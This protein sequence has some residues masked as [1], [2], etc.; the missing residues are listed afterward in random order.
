MLLLRS[1]RPANR[2]QTNRGRWWASWARQDGQSWGTSWPHRSVSWRMPFSP[3]R[4]SKA[5]VD[6]SAPVVSVQVGHVVHGVVEVDGVAALAPAQ[7][8]GFVDAAL[9]DGQGEQVGPA[10]GEVGRVEGPEAGPGDHHVQHALAVVVDERDHLVADPVLEPAV[11]DGAGL[12][13][14]VGVAPAGRVVAVDRVDLD[15]AGLDQ[16]GDGVDHAAILVVGAAALLGLEDQQR[17]AVVAVGQQPALGPDRR[18]PQPDVV[19]SQAHSSRSSPTNQGSKV[20]RQATQLWASRCSASATCQPRAARAS[21]TTRLPCRFSSTVPQV[22]AT[23]AGSAAPAPAARSSTKRVIRRKRG[24]SRSW[25]S[26][27]GRK[28]LPDW[29]NRPPKLA[30]AVRA[31]ARVARAPRLAPMPTR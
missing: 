13:G 4:R 31:A 25:S 12:Q 16:A 28:K 18:R 9:A 23:E 10:E 24:K 5:L 11:L 21:R 2:T 8:G 27:P 30:G 17:P 20:S 22:R 3:S 7:L 15:P 19:A 1:R 26:G 14:K 29:R 6:S